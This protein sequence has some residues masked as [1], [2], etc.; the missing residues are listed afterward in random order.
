MFTAKGPFIIINGAL[1]D[2]KKY[3]LELFGEERDDGS[4]TYGAL[5]KASG[6]VLL[7]DEVTEIPLETQSKIL[8]VIID[9]KFKRLNSNHDIRVDVR[10]ICSNSKD[11]I[12]E[13]NNLYDK[14][15]KSARS[16][17]KKYNQK[18]NR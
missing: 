6:G 3:E 7:I 8:R 2:A 15:F 1:L 16:I 10:I 9:Q 11:M 17:A 5:E 12:K 18:L 13:I 14:K 4:I